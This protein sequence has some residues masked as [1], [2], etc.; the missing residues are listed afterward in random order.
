MASFADLMCGPVRANSGSR[1]EK[2]VAAGG[3]GCGSG[4]GWFTNMVEVYDISSNTWETGWS[5]YVN[6]KAEY[7]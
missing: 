4:C 7:E 5:V 1:V 6:S 3:G 2:I